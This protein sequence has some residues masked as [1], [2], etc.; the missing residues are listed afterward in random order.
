MNVQGADFKTSLVH[1]SDLQYTQNTFCWMTSVKGKNF[2]RASCL[3]VISSVQRHH[4]LWEACLKQLAEYCISYS[5]VFS[6]AIRAAML[7]KQKQGDTAEPIAPID[8]T[9]ASYFLIQHECTMMFY[10]YLPLDGAIL[11]WRE[12]FKTFSF[13]FDHNCDG[14][15]L[16]IA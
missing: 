12:A 9:A 10:R 15:L 16:L 4:S 7:L 13:C 2:N 8:F 1:L 11:Y 3:Q 5:G 14:N 6:W